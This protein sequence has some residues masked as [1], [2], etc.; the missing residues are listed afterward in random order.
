MIKYSKRIDEELK[1]LGFD[2]V[3]EIFKTAQ[4]LFGMT[5]VYAEVPIKDAFSLGYDRIHFRIILMFPTKKWPYY[6]Q[7]VS[8]ATGRSKRDF[9]VESHR[10]IATTSAL[11]PPLLTREQLTVAI[12]AKAIE[13]QQ[14]YR[15]LYKILMME[16]I[17]KMRN[18]NQP[19]T[20]LR[21]K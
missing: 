11:N 3:K 8:A 17:F 6:I 10:V 9:Q 16:K 4:Q 20:G 13:E 14:G 12:R 1:Q 5:Y 7:H 15:Q 18:K 21:R 19:G 2:N